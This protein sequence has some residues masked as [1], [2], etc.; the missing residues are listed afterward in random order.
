VLLSSFCAACVVVSFNVDKR[1]VSA[2]AVASIVTD[3]NWT[4]T[5]CNRVSIPGTSETV[6]TSPK[7]AD[8]L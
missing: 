8:R 7:P 3:R 4:Q 2:A 6:F 5:S 1:H